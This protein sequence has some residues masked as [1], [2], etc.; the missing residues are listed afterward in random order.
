MI[1]AGLYS[2]L[3]GK[4]KENKEKKEQETMELPTTIKGIEGNGQVMDIAEVGEVEMEKA[5]ANNT[6]TTSHDQRLWQSESQFQRG[7]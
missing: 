4:Y 5:K 2:V 1:V 3:W 7:P 6:V